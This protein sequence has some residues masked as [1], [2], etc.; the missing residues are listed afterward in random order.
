M[1]HLQILAYAL[2]AAQDDA[3]KKF[4]LSALLLA[5]I[6]LPCLSSELPKACTPPGTMDQENFLYAWVSE[7]TKKGSNQQLKDANE[8]LWKLW[9][10]RDGAFVQVLVDNFLYLSERNASVFL[11][12]APS[13]ADFESLCAH[14]KQ[15]GIVSKTSSEYEFHSKLHKSLLKKMRNISNERSN[16]LLSQRAKIFAA[17]LSAQPIRQLQ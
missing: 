7:T 9:P 8:C 12:A 16:M 17:A 13:A 14:I 3:M 6:S 10:T 15:A 2:V 11:M 5:A 1:V 4:L